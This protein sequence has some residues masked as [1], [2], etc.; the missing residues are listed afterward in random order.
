MRENDDRILWCIIKIKLNKV[1][2]I[3]LLIQIDLINN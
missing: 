3:N 1:M 2:K